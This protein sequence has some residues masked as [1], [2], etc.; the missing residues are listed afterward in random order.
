MNRQNKGKEDYNNLSPKNPKESY[1]SKNYNNYDDLDNSQTEKSGFGEGG[2]YLYDPY[3][4]SNNFNRHNQSPITQGRQT[5]NTGGDQNRSPDFNKKSVVAS[6]RDNFNVKDAKKDDLTSMTLNMKD[7]KTRENSDGLVTTGSGDERSDTNSYIPRRVQKRST[8]S[9]NTFDKNK[10]MQ[11]PD[12]MSGEESIGNK[13]SPNRGKDSDRYMNEEDRQRE[14]MNQMNKIKNFVDRSP[15]QDYNHNSFNRN[16]RSQEHEEKGELYYRSYDHVPDEEDPEATKT[17]KAKQKKGFTKGKKEGG[18][19]AQNTKVFN[20]IEQSE[21]ESLKFLEKK[22]PVQNANRLIVILL[23][24]K[25]KGG[26]SPD[27][28]KSPRSGEK[29]DSPNSKKKFSRLAFAMIASRGPN[30]EDRVITKVMRGDES[31]G[32]VDLGISQLK[33]K[34]FEV[35]KFGREKKK[36]KEKSKMTFNPKLRQG[37]VKIIQK[38]WRDILNSFQ[39]LEGSIVKIQSIWRG[40]WYRKYLYDIIYY[41]YMTKAFV[42]KVNT[43]LRDRIRKEYFAKLQKEFA[44]KYWIRNSL[45]HIIRIQ[46]KILD[47]LKN[48]R[49]K[50]KRCCNLIDKI[51]QKKLV[52]GMNKI[53]SFAHGHENKTVTKSKLVANFLKKVIHFFKLRKFHELLYRI[54]TVPINE[55]KEEIF[56]KTLRF[57]FNEKA[58]T[59][60]RRFMRRWYKTSRAMDDNY[61]FLC[62]TVIKNNIMKPLFHQLIGKLRKIPPKGFKDRLLRRLIKDADHYTVALLKH[63]FNT[64]KATSQRLAVKEFKDNIGERFLFRTTKKRDQNAKNK[65]FRRW[66]QYVF[67]V[68][69]ITPY[70]DGLPQL[71]HGILRKVF[72]EGM[73]QLFAANNGV[74][75]RLLHNMFFSMPKFKLN[76]LRRY[77]GKWKKIT[78]HLGRLEA[79]CLFLKSLKRGNRSKV[80]RKL[81]MGRFNDWRRKAALLAFKNQETD[82]DFNRQ[83]MKA[84]IDL[85]GGLFKYSRRKAFKLIYTDIKKYL[86]DIIKSKAVKAMF[87]QFK[88]LNKIL[89]RKYFEKYR[90]IKELL[91]KQDLKNQM[92]GSFMKNFTLG[93]RTKRLFI[94]FN[95][96]HRNL[97]KHTLFDIQQGLPHF[98][99]FCRLKTF[100]H[101]I[102]AFD[103]KVDLENCQEAMKKALGFRGKFMK[104]KWKD[105]LL[106]WRKNA[107]YLRIKAVDGN[108][109][110]KFMKKFTKSLVHRLLQT[111]F[112]QWKYKKP[113]RMTLHAIFMRNRNMCDSVVNY[114]KANVL[115]LRKNF[116]EKFKATRGNKILLTAYHKLL[117]FA[118]NGKKL[119]KRHFLFRWKDRC[120][121]LELKDL[122]HQLM[123][124]AV[125]QELFKSKSKRLN[126][127]FNRWK[128]QIHLLR[129]DDHKKKYVHIYEGAEK[130]NNQINHRRIRFMSQMKKLMN[131]DTR[132]RI[133]HS[134]YKRANR[135]RYNISHAFERWRRRAGEMKK[136]ADMTNL[137]RKICAAYTQKLTKRME[138]DNLIKRFKLWRYKE[139]FGSH[140]LPDI[141]KGMP[142]FVHALKRKYLGLPFTLMMRTKNYRG[143]FER[144][145]PFGS[146]L[147]KRWEKNAKI[148]L[149]RLWVLQKDRAKTMELKARIFEQTNGK[150]SKKL[151]LQRMS[152]WFRKWKQN[153]YKRPLDLYD[154]VKGIKLVNNHMRR[155]IVHQLLKNAKF[156]ALENDK[157]K[158]T[159]AFL[160]SNKGFQKLALKS[161]FKQWWKKMLLFDDKNRPRVIR[162]I[163]RMLVENYIIGP[164]EKWFRRWMKVLYVKPLDGKNLKKAINHMRVYSLMKTLRTPVFWFY[165]C[166]QKTSPFYLEKKLFDKLLPN[167]K[168]LTKRYLQQNLRKWK[169]KSDAVAVMAVKAKM[170]NNLY[171]KTQKAL[172]LKRCL[173]FFRRWSE[174]NEFKK[175]I[176]LR[177]VIYMNNTL[178][179]VLARK[180]LQGFI[181]PKLKEYAQKRFLRNSLLKQTK[182]HRRALEPFFKRWRDIYEKL[183]A[184]SMKDIFGAKVLQKTHKYLHN[185]KFREILKRRFK[186]WSSITDQINEYEKEVT[187]QLVKHIKRVNILKNQPTFMKNLRQTSM[188]VLK[189]RFSMALF[190][191]KGLCKGHTL[192][193]YVRLWQKRV[194]QLQ[195]KDVKLSI[196]KNM[197]K[198]NDTK[199][200]RMLKQRAFE[201]FKKR[202]VYVTI[203]NHTAIMVAK[204]TLKRLMARRPWA[205]FKKK[206]G[207]MHL[208]VPTGCTMSQA[209]VRFNPNICKSMALRNYLQRRYFKRWLKTSQ[210]QKT[211]ELEANMFKKLFMPSVKNSGKLALRRVFRIWEDKAQKMNLFE[212]KCELKLGLMKNMYANNSRLNL[213]K[214]FH[215]WHNDLEKY[216]KNL[217]RI[218][219]GFEKLRYRLKRHPWKKFY[220][221]V[222]FAGAFD[223]TPIAKKILMNWLKRTQ[224]GALFWAFN[225][226]NKKIGEIKTLMLKHRIAKNIFKKI[227]M[228]QTMKDKLALSE[229]FLFWRIASNKGNFDFLKTIRFGIDLLEKG[230]RQPYN[231]DVWDNIAR[232]AKKVKF[233]RDLQKLVNKYD[234]SKKKAGLQE[235]FPQWREQVELIN[236]DM[237]RRFIQM[238]KDHINGPLR[239]KR[240]TIPVSKLLGFAEER[241]KLK[242]KSANKIHKY[243]RNG[244]ALAFKNLSMLR[245]QRLSYMMNS[246]A[247]KEQGQLKIKMMKWAFQANMIELSTNVKTIQNYIRNKMEEVGAKR[248]VLQNAVDHT[249]NHI[250]KIVFD[251]VKEHSKKKRI[252]QL[253]LRNMRDIPKELKH[254]FLRK[255]MKIWYADLIGSQNRTAADLINSLCRRFFAIKLKKLLQRKKAFMNKVVLKLVGKL[256]DKQ[257]I[258]LLLWRLNARQMAVKKAANGILRWLGGRLNN[259]NN[260]R[261]LDNIRNKF[262]KYGWKFIKDAM[263]FS[264]KVNKERG[265]ILYETLKDIYYKRPFNFIKDSSKWKSRLR[266]LGDVLPKILKCMKNFYL[267]YYVG[268]WRKTAEAIYLDNLIR[269]QGMVKGKLI[270]LKK[271]AQVR[272]S[273]LATKM[274]ARLTN[275]D[276]LKKKIY[277]HFW[278]TKAKN[279]S[280]QKATNL[281]SSIWKG[282]TSRK[283]MERQRKGMNLK[284]MFKRY[285][286][287]KI[288]KDFVKGFDSKEALKRTLSNMSGKYVKRYA[289][290]NILDYANNAI[291]N[292]LLFKLTNNA[293]FN[294]YYSTLQRYFFRFRKNTDY[295]E[296][297]ALRIQTNWRI[298]ESKEKLRLKRKC[299]DLLIKKMKKYTETDKDKKNL[300]FQ[301]WK[302]IVQMGDVI[303]S[304]EV[305]QAFLRK[306]V[307]NFKRQSIKDFFIKFAKLRNANLLKNGAKAK[308]LMRAV[309][310]DPLRRLIEALK[311]DILTKKLKNFI[312]KRFSDIDDQLKSLYI[313]K[314][315]LDWKKQMLKIQNRRMAANLLIIK[316]VR[317]FLARCSTGPLLRKKRIMTKLRDKFNNTMQIKFQSALLLWMKKSKLMNTFEAAKVLQHFLTI[318]HLKAK[319]IKGNNKKNKNHLAA[320]AVEKALNKHDFKQSFKAIKKYAD[321]NYY[322]FL[323]KR[324]NKKITSYR[325]DMFDN[326]KLRNEKREAG[327]LKIQKEFKN[328]MFGRK[329]GQVLYKIQ[330][331]R[332]ILTMMS[333]RD[334]RFKHKCLREWNKRAIQ[335][336][337]NSAAQDVQLFLKQKLLAY[338]KKQKLLS[339]AKLKKF[340]ILNVFIRKNLKPYAKHYDNDKRF[341][342]AVPLIMRYIF[343]KFHYKCNHF[344]LLNNV[345]VIYNTRK[346]IIRRFMKKRFGLWR[347][348]SEKMKM[349]W[350]V[351]MIRK[352][353]KLFRKRNSQKRLKDHMDNMLKNLALKHSDKKRFYFLNLWSITKKIKIMQ[354]S[355]SMSAFTKK[356]LLRNRAMKKWKNWMSRLSKYENSFDVTDIMKQIRKKK[357]FTEMFA[358]Y[359]QHI[360]ENAWKEFVHRL[361]TLKTMK[362]VKLLFGNF[363][364]RKENLTKLIALRR[365][366]GKARAMKNND[367]KVTAMFDAIVRR[368]K[369]NSAETMANLFTYRRYHKLILKIRE[370]YAFHQLKEFYEHK[371][372]I[373]KFFALLKDS[374]KQTAIQ[375]KKV[376]NQKMHAIYFYNIIN[377]FF[378]KIDNADKRVFRPFF[379]KLFIDKLSQNYF[380]NSLFKYDS[381]SKDKNSQR[382]S[383]S[384]HFEC[385]SFSIEDTPKEKA[386]AQEGEGFAATCMFGILQDFIRKRKLWAYGQLWSKYRE[387]KFV[388]IIKKNMQKLLPGKMFLENLYQKYLYELDTPNKVNKLKHMFRLSTL[389]NIFANNLELVRRLRLRYFLKIAMMDKKISEFRKAKKY[390]RKW[391]YMV[392]I[393]NVARDKMMKLYQNMHLQFL[394]MASDMF[395]DEGNGIFNEMNNITEKFGA[396]TSDSHAPTFYK[397]KFCKEVKQKYR[398]DIP[399]ITANENEEPV[400]EKKAEKIPPTK[401]K[402]KKK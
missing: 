108:L 237:D 254:K 214:H 182:Y 383:T 1:R 236:E 107:D 69:D 112:R 252:M 270:L 154:V 70:V 359:K 122:R 261:A 380:S 331:L 355:E 268:K 397:K 203:Q 56:N 166:R 208:K 53:K 201:K 104:K 381:L 362:L 65:Y 260:A 219:L 341:T 195:V 74:K 386:R 211:K 394:N 196:F 275:D 17:F 21:K 139:F 354:A 92:V 357:N 339:K 218:T 23:N 111:K 83:K 81:L 325:R 52:H 227:N 106:I 6:V 302:T 28:K 229:K 255:Y 305:I 238:F 79:S 224:K 299:R 248:S 86:L 186:L 155:P 11:R 243:V 318:V 401:T 97:P 35:K 385:M 225:T 363:E 212:T 117:D 77:L 18:L 349:S 26:N 114:I 232:K 389:K 391:N 80:V 59:N 137:Q 249:K 71:K 2:V 350:A 183:K 330:R 295:V 343:R 115:A 105:Y 271:R 266:Q 390:L 288:C 164:K 153:A 206:T 8:K 136:D 76:I 360:L 33:P 290:N 273:Y 94:Y 100:Y 347:S 78:S 7:R 387:M 358:Q 209:L 158:A 379:Q 289:T 198:L 177:H 320:E 400:E 120:K 296:K 22:K 287:K 308:K 126:S 264:S 366:L 46:R 88:F 313:R 187:P 216:Y 210:H 180:Y 364:K 280:L 179:S 241:E 235:K 246:L 130:L 165:K 66:R 39:G 75:G 123:R 156:K 4:S 9:M 73:P 370:K 193:N 315:L 340:T 49:D 32:V 384:L 327:A 272:K 309:T 25:E 220:Q 16:A 278:Q 367:E 234:E 119:K 250:N 95:K 113:A 258:Y 184:K 378:K 128:N 121:D 245:F 160:K 393:K 67:R 152:K 15:G 109:A 19:I 40:F 365:W 283:N 356:Y 5:T 323:A 142:I 173:K 221:N 199:R 205:I 163:R 89:L 333:D 63:F 30:C 157:K 298:V 44:H 368:H 311:Y 306:R 162:N 176:D 319:R 110:S 48:M 150:Y 324:I 143:L 127:F 372:R 382:A 145:M 335:I 60:I 373:T 159:N 72:R 259:M 12:Y 98:Q 134:I 269:I 90:K 129:M 68:N 147:Q 10:N 54:Y 346:K 82:A 141:S 169:R 395:G 277:L 58:K 61:K 124:M 34:K 168:N 43:P 321:K 316:N 251:N 51:Y 149:W 3:D 279:I 188:D 135:P 377:K 371:K 399:E 191:K 64:W 101:I 231:R 62:A 144:I 29:G 276:E 189:K 332:F 181:V 116:W 376:F 185:K 239:V 31:G 167:Y 170:M 345:G 244:L 285:Y 314:Y 45:F 57:S 282:N 326:I 197:L 204:D 353:W 338:R 348:L 253:L 36:E 41:T 265:N 24:N 38:W 96:W 207:M 312:V 374:N 256:M 200:K 226:W 267:P 307:E 42:E 223:K 217:N 274:M 361:K 213:R 14:H 50:K 262:R 172:Q 398:F 388:S 292:M 352:Y 192:R 202:E 171:G 257:K 84:T 190:K 87:K 344:D 146:K 99:R 310:V 20:L 336:K 132:G 375:N 161:K 47:F 328:F 402:S 286:V 118:V 215:K 240:I 294:N 334:A 322:K 178:F 93:L 396:F 175:D 304:T 303:D 392:T 85:S 293:N 300:F 91:E 329:M 13:M 337:L 351:N 369:I 233:V 103:A 27:K 263:K 297:M 291:R 148:R 174:K 284:K 230:L 301:R 133:I 138:R 37:A 194:A 151:H 242:H 125:N 317:R 228:G 281:I 140:V 247:N 102:K 222:M 131:L 342:K 55:M